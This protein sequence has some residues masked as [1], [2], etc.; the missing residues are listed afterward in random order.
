MGF[1]DQVP[2]FKF[3]ILPTAAEPEIFAADL[4]TGIVALGT[5]TDLAVEIVDP[6][7]FVARVNTDKYFSWSASPTLYLDLVAP[8]ILLQ[9]ISAVNGSLLAMVL[10]SQRYHWKDMTAA[11]VAD[12]V[13]VVDSTN[14]FWPAFPESFEA[15][16]S[17]GLNGG[18]LSHLAKSVIPEVVPGAYGKSK[19]VEPPSVAVQPTKE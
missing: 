2:E 17:I 15:R 10:L 11:G 3:K 18:T 4:S 7:L 19:I 8:E 16:T 13:P 9:F 6:I 12:H 5:R 1:A 14:M